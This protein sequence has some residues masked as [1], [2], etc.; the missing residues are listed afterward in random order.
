MLPANEAPSQ[1]LTNIIDQPQKSGLTV[2]S[3][4]RRPDN[5][6]ILGPQFFEDP[7]TVLLLFTQSSSLKH[8]LPP[9]RLIIHFLGE[10]VPV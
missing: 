8:Q 7:N 2:Q 5:F 3:S 6:V 10:L 4:D 9:S 1:Y